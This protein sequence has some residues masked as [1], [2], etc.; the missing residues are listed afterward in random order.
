MRTE[1]IERLCINCRK[2]FKYKHPA[3]YGAKFCS[4][5]CG[6]D[7]RRKTGKST[8][9]K[10]F[11]TQC[12]FCKKKISLE[13]NEKRKN[14]YCTHKCSTD[15][16]RGRNGH[17][18]GVSNKLFTCK[19]CGKKFYDFWYNFRKYCSRAC[20]SK[21]RSKKYSCAICGKIF[22]DYKRLKRAVCSSSSCQMKYVWKRQKKEV[23]E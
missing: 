8:G 21:A 6:H 22:I 19:G 4:R 14:N 16:S 9:K 11:E 13:L 20:L 5:K 1:L 2:T 10:R 3:G 18:K 7:L 15:G 23:E 17:R 12:A